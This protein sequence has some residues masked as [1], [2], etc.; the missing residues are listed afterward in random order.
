[1]ETLLQLFKQPRNAFIGGVIVG[2]IVG[3][4]FAWEVWPTELRNATPS[5]LRSDFQRNYL[6]WVASQYAVD[7]DL[8]AARARLGAEFWEKGKLSARLN[9]LAGEVRGQDAV[10][11]REL[12]LALEGTP[13]AAPTARPEQPA[14]GGGAFR[15]IFL[16]CGV[17]L[18]VLACAAALLFLS[19]V[20]A[21]QP[22]SARVA[23][24]PQPMEPAPARGRE[25][26]AEGPPLAQFSTTYHLGDD[27]YDP[28]YSI[29]AEDGEFLGECGV[30][31]SE[32]IGA[33][34]PSKVT[35]FEVWLFDKSDIRTVTKVVM[36]D[37]AFHDEA[38]RTKLAPKGEPVLAEAGKQII[39]ETKTLRVRATISD[40]EYG[41]GNL[42][43]G[44]FFSRLAIDLDVW[45]L[46]YG[47]R[48]PVASDLPPTLR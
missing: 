19:R 47:N 21:R 42:P 33:G 20:R 44:S 17:A 25:W 41:T 26:G 1:M 48:P 43:P 34:T 5:H 15:S 38:L 4:F 3:L 37:Y 13:A 27:H 24:R 29:E 6:L 46:P 22:V 14:G 7:R 28:S 2:L 18:V 23:R 8:N 16:V 32:T 10:R 45:A 36:S 9:E 35:A 11:L 30:G 31:I 12:A 40:M 39:L